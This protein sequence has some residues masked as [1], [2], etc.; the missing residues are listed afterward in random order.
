[1][2]NHSGQ[3]AARLS[4]SHALGRSGED[5]AVAYL[6][7]KRFSVIERGFRFHRGEI[8]IIAYDSDTLVFI[9]VKTRRDKIFG[10]PEES[11]TP[12]KQTQLRRVAEAYLMVNNL[13]HV[14]CR[15]DIL[16]VSFDEKQGYKIRHLENA[17]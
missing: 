1:M 5:A 15:F 9:E 3:K 12:A 7:R 17:F 8:D 13:G 4:R 11:V 2:E 14:P 6:K 16:S 10:L